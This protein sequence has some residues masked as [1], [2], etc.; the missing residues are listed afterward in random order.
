MEITSRIKKIASSPYFYLLLIVVFGLGLRLINL[1]AQPLGGDEIYT[2][3]LAQHFAGNIPQLLKYLRE[4][5]YYPPLYYLLVQ[6]WL[7]LFGASNVAVRSLSVLFGLGTIALTYDFAWRVFKK[8]PVALVAAAIVAV[9]PMQLEFSQFA[10]V[11]AMFC[12]FGLLSAEMLWLYLENKRIRFLAGYVIASLVGIYLHYSF[13]FIVAATASWWGIDLLINEKNSSRDAIMWLFAHALVVVGFW[14]WLDA[15]LYKIILAGY[16][17]GGVI[18]NPPATRT[19]DFFEQSLRQLLWMDKEPTI[20]RIAIFVSWLWQV[21]LFC[22]L[23]ISIKYEGLIL[24]GERTPF[25]YIL[26][27]LCVPLVIF[28]FSPMSVPYALIYWRHVVLG[29]SLIAIIVAFL[30]F[31]LPFRRMLV[32]LS[33]LFISFIP[34]SQTVLGNDA[35][36]DSDYM[37]SGF[38]QFISEQYKKGDVVIV[39]YASMRTDLTHFLAPQIPVM[40]FLPLNYDEKFDWWNSRDTMGFL[41][42]EFERRVRLPDAVSMQQNLERIISKTKPKRV[43]LVGFFAKENAPIYL[44]FAGHDWR[45]SI[46]SSSDKSPLDMYTK[47]D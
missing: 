5:E 23:A 21:I 39:S 19:L 40:D 4:V 10:R 28:F 27:L 12:F 6:L 29:S 25:F 34:F 44:W 30:A 45:P 7:H 43:W 9:M 15:F 20:S 14:F 13:F 26:W 18:V 2:V 22:F 47:S 38:G 32:V 35:E 16:S 41:E 33:I 8:R 24:K 11:Y 31:K 46:R 37:L 17:I 42:V 1:A 3:D 36:W